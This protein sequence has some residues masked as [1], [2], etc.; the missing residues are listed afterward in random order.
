[1]PLADARVKGDTMT[2]TKYSDLPFKVGTDNI[3]LC[4]PLTT[5]QTNER[6]NNGWGR[7]FLEKAFEDSIN[8][9]GLVHVCSLL[10]N[11]QTDEYGGPFALG[12]QCGGRLYFRPT[13]TVR[14]VYNAETEVAITCDGKGCN[15]EVTAPE[16]PTMSDL[17][18]LLFHLMLKQMVPGLPVA[19]YVDCAKKEDRFTKKEGEAR[20]IREL[21]LISFASEAFCGIVDNGYFQSYG[22]ISRFSFGFMLTPGMNTSACCG[23][24]GEWLQLLV[25]KKF[26][27]LKAHHRALAP[28]LLGPKLSP[29]K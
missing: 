9:S 25:E 13:S 28:L 16:C 5:V 18:N 6:P 22:M 10:C 1:M 20:L 19:N 29:R 8:L 7:E 21:G 23:N 26:E 2:H 11:S 14:S 17:S 27:S 3:L 4:Q 24:Y 12:P 15:M